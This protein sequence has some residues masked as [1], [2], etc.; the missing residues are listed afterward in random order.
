[1]KEGRKEGRKEVLLAILKMLITTITDEL[2]DVW[3]SATLKQQI[4][5]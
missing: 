4:F 2:P 3:F 5:C 1:V